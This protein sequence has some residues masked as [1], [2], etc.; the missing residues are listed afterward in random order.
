ML[1][2]VAGVA[3]GQRCSTRIAGDSQQGEMLKAVLLLAA[4]LLLQA[5]TFVRT[6]VHSQTGPGPVPNPDSVP[7]EYFTAGSLQ[8][9]LVDSRRRK[10]VPDLLTRIGRQ[11]VS[12][13]FSRGEYYYDTRSDLK[14]RVK[15]VFDGARFGRA[16]S[17]VAG[18][19]ELFPSLWFVTDWRPSHTGG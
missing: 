9:L 11:R 13:H 3:L 14:V 16:A 8:R 12:L 18:T 7:S 15:N 19:W 10:R 6:S 1:G 2:R 17:A 5:A 4:M